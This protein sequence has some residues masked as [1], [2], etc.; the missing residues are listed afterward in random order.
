MWFSHR[1]QRDGG[2]SARGLCSAEAAFAALGQLLLSITLIAISMAVAIW[3]LPRGVWTLGLGIAM[4]VALHVV[5]YGVAK[6][7]AARP[8]G[9]DEAS[10][11]S[12][13]SQ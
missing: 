13:I 8:D 3:I 11:D 9:G 4:T 5:V 7:F 12:G 6:M 10:G 2:A 1:S